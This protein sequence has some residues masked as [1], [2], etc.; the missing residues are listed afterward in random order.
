MERGR[1]WPSAHGE[2]KLQPRTCPGW[3]V[4]LLGKMF[5][6]RVGMSYFL[7]S[8]PGGGRGGCWRETRRAQGAAL[9]AAIAQPLA[10]AQGA[11]HGDPAQGPA[12]P[13][14]QQ[15]RGAQHSLTPGASTGPSSRPLI[16]QLVG[17]AAGVPAV[18]VPGWEGRRGQSCAEQ[19]AEERAFQKSEG[20]RHAPGREMARGQ[21]A[22]PSRPLL[23]HG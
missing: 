5:T 6:L 2:G 23:Q 1:A 21:Q 11:G 20:C 18:P 7:C 4:S 8:Q 15:G 9:A 14:R 22:G 3:A 17:M 19:E 16:L 10:C 12:T 13:P